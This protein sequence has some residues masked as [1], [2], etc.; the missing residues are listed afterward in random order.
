MTFKA[1]GALFKNT[2]EKLQQRLG[3]RF[4]P[5][6]AYPLFDGTFSIKEDERLAFATYVMN[7]PANDRGEI[8]G[9]MSGWAKQANSGQSYL[10]LAIEPDFKTQKAIQEKELAGTA[11]QSL[12]KAT[13][14][15]VVE[16]DLF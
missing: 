3:D 16:A 9:K 5:N 7:A 10:S 1:N 2:P 12:A 4:D 15:D 14:G 13:G 8:P 6:K 11:A